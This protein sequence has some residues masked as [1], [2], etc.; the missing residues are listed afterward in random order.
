MKLTLPGG[1]SARAFDQALKAFTSV[2]GSQWVLATDEDRRTY[3]DAYAPGNPESYGPSAA[4]APQTVEEIQALLRIANEH[5]VPL[6]PFSRGKNLGYG[7]SAPCMQGTVILDLSRMK[8]I[9]E[10][11]EKLAYCLV[12]PGVGFF[13]LY[14]HLQSNNIKLWMSIPANGWGSVVGNAMDRGLSYTPYGEHSKRVCGMEVVMPNG[15]IVRTGLGAMKNSASWQ[16]SQNAFGPSWDQMFMQSNFGVVTKMGLW[17]MPEPE[18]TLSLSTSLPNPDDLEWIIDALAPLRLRGLIQHDANIGNGIRA[19]TLRSQRDEWYQG[20]GPMPQSVID[21]MQKKLGLG[22]WNFTLRFYGHEEMNT[23]GARIVKEAIAKHA[24]VEFRETRWHRGEVAARDAGAGV[25]SVNALQVV[26]WRG[27]RGGH[28]GFSPI[29][30]ATGAHA[31]KQYRLARRRYEEH[32]FDYFG[33]FTIRERHLNHVTLCVYD[34]D[35]AAMTKN[36]RDLMDVLVKDAAADGYGE[37]R[38]HVMYMDQIADTYDY[39]NR[40]LWRLNE[41]LKDAVD[42]N[43]ILAPGK[44]GI[45]PKAMRGKRA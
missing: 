10:V 9:L 39:N 24:E 38:A 3:L 5:K 45:W 22:A 28:I 44:S 1:V 14:E 27:G 35:D 12:E 8:R 19:A 25:P 26:N 41:T 20:S 13:D 36:A 31:I 2:V 40:A 42:P 16:L 6:W 15:E 7:G 33:S 34:R 18:A 43:G 21:A 37:Y 29:S 30:P 32:G 17:L 23:I 4:V 11:D